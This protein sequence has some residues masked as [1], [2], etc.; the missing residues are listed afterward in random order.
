MKRLLIVGLILCVGVPSVFADRV[1]FNSAVTLSTPS[2]PKM[3]WYIDY[4]SALDQTLQVKYRWL[5]SN[6]SPILFD[7]GRTWQMWECKN[8]AAQLEADC[9]SAGVPY[10]GCTG[11][12]T[13][14]GLDP[15]DDCFSDVFAFQIRSQDVGTTIGT[16]LRT[17]IWNKFKSD[18]LPANTGTFDTE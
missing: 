11:E 12:G 14:S 6:G 9:V 8:V 17:L 13:G 3:D 5:D 18:V 15:G 7:S 16:G 2:S 1:T 10:P 4:I